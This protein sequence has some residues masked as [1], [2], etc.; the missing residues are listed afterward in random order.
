MAEYIT[1]I[2][3]PT[4]HDQAVAQADAGTPTIIYV[5]N[6]VTPACKAFT[7]KF[8]HLASIHNAQ[9]VEFC[10]MDYNHE[11]SMLF[12]FAPNQLP[13][14][15]L[16]VNGNWCRTVTGLSAAAKYEGLRSGIEELLEQAGKKEGNVF[17]GGG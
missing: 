17:E 16:M 2:L 5:C 4:E 10:Q 9:G 11:T 15:T 13:V 14:I 3:N 1:H 12:K 6:S 8:H 7:P